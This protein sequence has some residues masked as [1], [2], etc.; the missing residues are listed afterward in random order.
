M[1]PLAPKVRV[2]FYLA[3]VAVAGVLYPPLPV[4]AATPQKIPPAVSGADCDD[5]VPRTF[6]YL[7]DERDRLLQTL[8]DR[9]KMDNGKNHDVCE[10][11]ASLSRAE[12][13]VFE[14][15][16]AYLG[17]CESRLAP[18]P[19]DDTAL[20]HA[21]TLYSINGPGLITDKTV[22]VTGPPLGPGG[23]FDSNRI[24]IGFHDS[25]IDDMKKRHKLF[26][27]HPKYSL[28]TE[29]ND[30]GGVHAPFSKRDMICWG[31]EALKENRDVVSGLE[32]F[33]CLIPHGNSTGPSWD[34][35]LDENSDW[36]TLDK[37]CG[38]YNV[39]DKNLV[40]LS[41]ALDWLHESNV[42]L[43]GKWRRLFNSYDGS[44]Q[45]GTYH[46]KQCPDTKPVTEDPDSG[47]TYAGLGR[48]ENPDHSCIPS[49]ND[50]G[51]AVMSSPATKPTTF[52]DG[53]Q[54]KSSMQQITSSLQQQ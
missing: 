44:A 49:K 7:D 40:E 11:W 24:Y 29:S 52:T 21:R 13:N 14:M 10:L 12:R 5:G 15:V 51:D 50:N 31:D 1:T 9:K 28:W 42:T 2:Y 54:I 8:V 19:S 36:N 48:P 39:R 27:R 18:S 46:P 45:F 17:S 41:V 3:T 25:V 22:S 26:N 35:G 47:G 33:W 6:V 53:K 16:T 43:E 34:F 38:V 20:K 37:R 23:G 32:W 30:G 4:F